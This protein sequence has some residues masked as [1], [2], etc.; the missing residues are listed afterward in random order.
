MRSAADARPRVSGRG[1]AARRRLAS[2]R[3]PREKGEGGG[4]RDDGRD[5]IENG[6]LDGGGDDDDDLSCINYSLAKLEF[7]GNFPSPLTFTRNLGRRW[8]RPRPNELRSRFQE[9]GLP[10]CERATHSRIQ[11]L[12]KVPLLF[13]LL[14]Q[15]FDPPAPPAGQSKKGE[16]D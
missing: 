16:H 1:G 6:H 7:D 3:E 8:E 12:I 13:G 9:V 15:E 5:E 4:E 2:E 11:P 10:S 14:G